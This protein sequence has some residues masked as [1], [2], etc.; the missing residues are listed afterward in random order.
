MIFSSLLFI[1]AFLPLSLGIYYISPKKIK[2]FSLLFISAAFCGTFSVYLP[3]FMAV[4]AMWNYAAG[5]ASESLRKHKPLSVLAA[6]VGIAGD[7]AVLLFIRTDLFSD[8][9]P[10]NASVPVGAVF[11]TL[12]AIGYVADICFGKIKAE[13]NFLKFLLYI[14]FFPKL[15]MGPLVSY[16]KFSRM[17]GK[18]EKSLSELGVGLTIFVKGLAKKV[19]FAD[20]LFVLYSSVSSMEAESLS[21]LSAWLGVLAYMLCLYFTISGIS[22]MGTGLA[23]CFGFRFTRSF[24]YPTFSMGINDYCSRWHIPLVR[25]FSRYIIKPVTDKNSNNILRYAIFIMSWGAIGLCYEFSYGKL[26]WGILI[27]AAAVVEKIMYDSKTLKATAIAYTFAVT[28][29]CTVFFMGDSLS[30]SFHYLFAMFG[31]NNNLTD[32]AAFYLLKSYIAV[33]LVGIYVSTDLF[34][35]L[36]ERA[37]KTKMKKIAEFTSPIVIPAL[38]AICTALISYS[39]ASEIQL[40]IM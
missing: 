26:T 21:A 38:L 24:N 12:S 34:R 17:L 5:L 14:I 31:G 23:R 19:L 29:I 9:S 32:P 25:W 13:R 27:G 2:A 39:G 10:I 7:I 22:D 40:F 36:V 1:Y 15:L 28:S 20:N 8:F 37:G 4:Y 30:Y 33:L 3:V 16:S 18:G 11:F 35:N 6:S